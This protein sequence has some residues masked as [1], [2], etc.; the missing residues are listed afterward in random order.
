MN[1]RIHWID[2]KALERDDVDE[3]FGLFEFLFW[4]VRGL[5]NVLGGFLFHHLMV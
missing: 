4:A 3:K 1:K 5:K 2:F